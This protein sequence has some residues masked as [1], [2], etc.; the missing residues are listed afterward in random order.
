[1]EIRQIRPEDAR[2]AASLHIE[3]QPGTF[4]TSLG[5]EFLTAFY[6]GLCDSRWGYSFVAVEGDNPL[7]VIVG[8]SDTRALFKEFITKRGVHLAIPVLRRLLSRPSLLG[9]VLQSFFYPSKVG[10]AS[11]EDESGAA[12]EFLFI[13][14][15]VQARRQH[16]GSKML[17]VLIEESR[18]RGCTALQSTVHVDNRESN[19][20]H[21]KFG[22]QIV[23][24][25]ELHGKKM[26]L[27]SLPLQEAKSGREAH[28]GD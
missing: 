20:F 28:G 10:A 24:S 6:A 2:A 11:G 27:Y 18:R 26:N 19:A 15:S 8:A 13:G 7:G 3:G 12:A 5:E 22:F 25:M 23:G 9:G 17:H 1:M 16:I 14:V 21:E 4:L